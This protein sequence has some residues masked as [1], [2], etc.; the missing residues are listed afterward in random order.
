ML[1]HWTESDL[2]VNGLTFHFYRTGHGEKPPLVLLHGFSDNGL[3]WMPLARDLEADYDLILPDARGHGL[4]ARVQPGEPID[5][6]ADVAGLIEALNLKTPIV[7]GHS[8]GGQT[9]T[10]LGAHYP[11]LVSALIL[12]DPAWIDPA[13]EETPPQAN[14]FFEWLRQLDQYTQ[15]ELIAKGHAD[16][17]TWPESELPAWAESKRQLDINLLATLRSHQPWRA[18]VAAIQSPTLLITA[19]VSR[20]A[21]VTSAMAQE[22]AALSPFI[23]VASV[24]NA[25]HNIRRENY[26]AY[27]QA[28]K[29]FL[30]SVE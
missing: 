22:A 10:L 21:I 14:P 3:C 26:P 8:M 5:A 6:A 23:Q 12:E 20:H 28:V 24:P 9:A 30:K 1:P 16:N 2:T 11:Q 25:G 29:T 13:P 17:P 18:A 4:S 27:L 7:G 15:E 19:E